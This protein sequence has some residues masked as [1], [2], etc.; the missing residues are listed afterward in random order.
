MSTRKI[1]E[2]H[3]EAYWDRQGIKV[4]ACGHAYTEGYGSVFMIAH[5]AD[6]LDKY[7]QGK[8]AE[9][10]NEYADTLG[11]RI[12]GA[13]IKYGQ[14]HVEA[15]DIISELRDRANRYVDGDD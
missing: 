12:S 14:C 15:Q 11:Y 5:I 6:E 9:A 1:L 3:D 8:C 4:C 7:V 2:A 13:K 10:L